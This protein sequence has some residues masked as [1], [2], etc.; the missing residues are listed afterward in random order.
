MPPSHW[1]GGHSAR[2]KVGGICFCAAPAGSPGGWN[3]QPA[4]ALDID[5]PRNVGSLVFGWIRIDVELRH[6]YRGLNS[7]PNTPTRSTRSFWEAIQSLY[8]SLNSRR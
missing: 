7:S 5:D 6:G 1:M 4:V 8:V 3:A 2:G